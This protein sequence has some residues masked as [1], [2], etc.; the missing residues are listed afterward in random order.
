MQGGSQRDGS[1]TS[2][3][4]SSDGGWVIRA[5]KRTVAL[6]MQGSTY[7][8]VFAIYSIPVSFLK[9]PTGIVR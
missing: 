4:V 7:K 3:P 6:D 9:Q 5:S 2:S 8:D 1:C